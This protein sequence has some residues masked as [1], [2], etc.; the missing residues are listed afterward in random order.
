MTRYQGAGVV[1]ILALMFIHTIQ[2][3]DATFGIMMIVLALVFA[4]IAVFDGFRRV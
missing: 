1:A 2:P 3:F 4:I